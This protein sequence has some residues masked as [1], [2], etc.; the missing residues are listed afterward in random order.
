[1]PRSPRT[2]H[3]APR[4]G[5]PCPTPRVTLGAS[6]TLPASVSPATLHTERRGRC[7]PRQ[8]RAKVRPPHLL[9]GPNRARAAAR[10]AGEP[11]LRF[12]ERPGRASGPER[13]RPREGG[14][15]GREAAR[16][17]N[18][19]GLACR[20][21]PAKHGPTWN[22][23]S[24]AGA[25]A[26]AFELGC[27]FENCCGEALQRDTAASIPTHFRS[28][29]L[30]SAPLA[31]PLDAAART[32][33]FYGSRRYIFNSI[34]KK[35]IYYHFEKRLVPA[36]PTPVS[37]SSR[38]LARDAVGAPALARKASRELWSAD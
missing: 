34:G 24:P 6:L 32:P 37:S 33:A 18:L 29:G 3:T 17:P 20:S 21:L 38:V 26:D 27:T 2:A 12:R 7:P 28:G 25:T 15:L 11:S 1:M 19:P 9:H 36:P 16:S 14:S 13:G 30:G 8:R 4:P 35:T 10:T 22:W 23:F 5:P 31:S